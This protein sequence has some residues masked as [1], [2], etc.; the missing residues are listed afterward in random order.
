MIRYSTVILSVLILVFGNCI[1]NASGDYK[2]KIVEPITETWRWQNF[3]ELSNK[4]C[5]CMVEGVDNLLWFGVNGGVIKYD[6][7]DWEFISL[8]K[9]SLRTPVVS[10]LAASDGTLYAGTSNNIFELNN[11]K[12]KSLPIKLSFGDSTDFPYNRYPLIE[13]S[14]KSIWIGSRHG[15]LRIKNHNITLYREEKSFADIQNTNSTTEL[16]NI[17]NLPL[18]DIYSIYEDNNGKMWFGLRDGRI[19]NFQIPINYPNKNPD[20]KRVDKEN[21]YLQSKYPLISMDNSEKIYTVSGEID[22]GIQVFEKGKW[23]Q[24]KVNQFFGTD[25]LQNDIILLK[26]GVICIAGIGRIFFLKD[27][28]WKMFD[29]TTLPFPSNRLRLFQTKNENLWIIGLSK[30]VWR[31]DLTLNK[32]TTYKDILFQ[33]EGGDGDKWFITVDGKAA[34]FITKKDKWTQYD[35]SDGLIDC[36]VAITVTRNGDVWAIGS[37]NHTAATAHFDGVRWSK[38]LHPKISWG[39][40]RRAILES[41][42]GSLWLGSTSDFDV[43]KGQVGG[44]VRYRNSSIFDVSE[45]K[46]KYYP[47]NNEFNLYGIYGIGQTADQDIW[48]G[49]LGFYNLNLITK[50]WKKISEPIGLSQNFIDCIQSDINGDIWVGTRTNGLFHLNH[51]NNEWFQYTI[52]NGL[53]SNSIIDAICISN[54]NIWIA[55]DKD[56]SHF[57]GTNWTN[58]VFPGVFKYLRD[59]ITIRSTR[60]GSI[61]INQNPPVWYRR[62]L[63]KDHYKGKYAEEFKTVRYHPDKLP[64]ETF[65]TFSMDRVAQPGNVFLSWDA[66]DPWSSTPGNQIQY[67]YRF[68][69]NEWSPY[70]GEKSKIF[71]SIESGEHSFEVKSRNRDMN[72]DSTPAKVSFYV[73]PPTWEEPWFIALILVFSST[74]I[75]FIIFLYH[76]NKIIQELSETRAR[77]FTNISHELKTP[78]TLIM[79]SMS[80]IL[81]PV[82]VNNELRQSL[83]LMQRNCQR[84]LRLINQILDYRKIELGQM[85]FEPSN[86]DIIDF[87]KEEFISFSNEA[88]A[89]KIDMSFQSEVDHLNIWFDPDKIEKIMFNLLSNAIKFTLPGNIVIVEIQLSNR[90]NDNIIHLNHSKYIKVERWLKIIVRDT[91]IGISEFNLEKI[92]DR[93]YQVQDHSSRITGG[94]GI[95]LSVAKEMVKI[96]FGEIHVESILGSGTTF[97]VNIPVIPENMIDGIMNSSIIKKSDYVIAPKKLEENN[98]ENYANDKDKSKILIIEDNPDMRYYIKSELGNNYQIFEAIDGLDGFNKSL[99]FGPDLVISDIMMPQMDGVELCKKLKLDERTSHIAVILLTARSSQEDFL[100]GLQT[101]ADD[102]LGKPFNSEELRL[103]AHNIIESRKKIREKFNNSINIGPKSIAIT[104]VDQKLMEK[105]LDII[106]KHLDDNEFTVETFSNLLGMNRVSLY[107]KIKSLTNLSPREFFT[108]IRLKRAAQLLK[109]SGLTITEIAFQVGFRDSSHF[110]KLFKKQFGLTPKEYSKMSG[111]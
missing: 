40:D 24:I 2:P 85:K 101:G 103:R 12:W 15:A 3:P 83:N 94:T 39:L 111:T 31:I 106:D 75:L 91:G 36:P 97:T 61:W 46:Y 57:D 99:Q 89:K 27:N 21:E 64:P 37:H 110:S 11:G 1:L 93:F 68:D 105:V 59:G 30:D 18:F 79:G 58:D 43:N 25:D 9:D 100:I 92:F 90:E 13:A 86:S 50:K 77:L 82:E 38:Q 23:N 62:A 56:I 74:I 32:W 73:I 4:G 22:K 44:L 26:N 104:S 55:T 33:A 76:R 54:K 71:L 51:K 10:L 48:V 78:L 81:E 102:Y 108:V 49:Q 63:F 87:I 20:W 107:H 8:T 34:R 28:I 47:C 95:G 72:V 5:Q 14:D 17:L 96:H 80:K 84:L 29:R 42:D 6:G 88:K 60:D 53:P 67:S 109:E 65:I 52:K 69:N 16:N 98:E 35:Q 45:L 41:Y 66:N 19:Y 7:L 70:S